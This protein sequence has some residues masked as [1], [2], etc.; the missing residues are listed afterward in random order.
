MNEFEAVHFIWLFAALV[1]AGSGLASYRLS[2]KRRLSMGLIWCGIFAGV[3]LFIE[4][5]L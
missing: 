4:M 3:T 1:L 2:W 5:V